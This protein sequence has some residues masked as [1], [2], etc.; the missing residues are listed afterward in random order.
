MDQPEK[1]EMGS[2]TVGTAA[3]ISDSE[4]AGADTSNGDREGV[5]RQTAG[6]SRNSPMIRISG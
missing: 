5:Q 4:A 6:E 1:R 3:A 2:T